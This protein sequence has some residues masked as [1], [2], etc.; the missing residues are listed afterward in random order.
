MLNSS[1]ANNPLASRIGV[2]DTEK[3]QTGRDLARSRQRAMLA[4]LESLHTELDADA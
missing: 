2:A 4:Y 3:T 1:T